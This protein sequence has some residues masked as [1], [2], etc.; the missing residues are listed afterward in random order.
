MTDFS[1]RGVMCPKEEANAFCWGVTAA[2]APLKRLY[3]K[4]PPL[5][6]DEV[7]I[8]V[9]HTG[10]CH[11]DCFKID[12]EWGKN[13]L[14]PLVPGHEIIAEI[15]KVGSTV[16]KFKPGDQVSFGVF[17][18]CCGSCE[19]CRRGDDQLCSGCEYKFT[20]DPHLGGY[21][22]HMHVKAG[23]VFHLPAKLDK[24]R[25]APIL[26]AGA[27]VFSPLRRWCIPGARCGIIGIGG[28]GHMALQV[29]SK[30][31][32]H[33]VAISSTA[34]K[35]AE[36]RHFGAKEFI[37]SKNEAD[38]KRIMTTEKLDIILNTAFIPDVTNYMYAVKAGGC[39]IEVGLPEVSKPVLFNNLDLVCGQKIF[40]GSVVGSRK[41]VEDTLSFCEKFDIMPV[42]ENYSWA[43]F[44]KAYQHLHEGKA[45]YRC[46]VD[47]AD[48]FD[49]L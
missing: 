40:T 9:L 36:A 41:E 18:D 20:Y 48:T 21:S 33:V 39:F 38:M 14:F 16:T 4:L 24:K 32:M 46:V 5:E 47:T 7:R 37:S 31:G 26:C 29:A 44:P 22:S 11:S 1:F 27:T 10:L 17:R 6:K 12:E 25:A 45:R 2:K 30:M 23:F 43:D 34:A 28:L 13:C 3:F 49:N 42:V 8:K 15:E 35:E 19:F